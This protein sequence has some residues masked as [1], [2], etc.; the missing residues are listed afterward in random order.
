MARVLIVPGLAVRGYVEPAVEQLAAAGVEA[1]LLGAPGEPGA[2]TDLVDYGERLGARIAQADD[3]VDA[4]IG[5]SVG[6]QVVAVAAATTTKVHHVLLVSPTV[7][8][9]ARSPTKLLGR[10]IAHSRLEPPRL[11]LEQAPDWRRAGARRIKRVARSAL[12]VCIED[13][14]SSVTARLTVVHAERD[15]ITSHGYAAALAAE[16]GG[17][18]VVVPGA[19]HSWPYADGYRFAQLVQRTTG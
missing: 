13:F 5:L 16:H 6:A 3:T 8:P 10:F 7:D 11:G 15:V 18:L 12:D 14:L 17:D 19:A 9:E 2:P 4:L 1:E